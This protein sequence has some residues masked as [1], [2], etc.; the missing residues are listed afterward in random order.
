MASE[1]L[2]AAARRRLQ[3]VLDAA[4]QEARA[5]QHILQDHI[6]KF[7]AVSEEVT[8]VVGGSTQQVDLAMAEALRTAIQHSQTAVSALTAAARGQ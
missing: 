7:A 8:A 1:A 6:T 2:N 3:A 4:A 5:T